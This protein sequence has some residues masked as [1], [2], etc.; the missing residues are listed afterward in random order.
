MSK[1]LFIQTINSMVDMETIL[2]HIRL[3]GRMYMTVFSVALQMGLIKL[4]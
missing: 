4:S 3:I 1:K 2:L